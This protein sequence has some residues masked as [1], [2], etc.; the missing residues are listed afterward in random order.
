M[1]YLVLLPE[2]RIWI[3]P[4]PLFDRAVQSCC[5]C[6]ISPVFMFETVCTTCATNT[7]THS[8]L[9]LWG[10]RGVRGTRLLPESLWK[11][12]S[13][14][15]AVKELGPLRA[16]CSSL[17]TYTEHERS[18]VVWSSEDSSAEEHIKEPNLKNPLKPAQ[19]KRL[20]CPI[21]RLT[22]KPALVLLVSTAWTFTGAQYYYQ[23]LMDYLENRLLA[24][25]VRSKTPLTDW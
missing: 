4:P 24:I 18:K 13:K 9:T 10:Q 22:M 25:E 6:A 8:T 12:S 16:A 19:T 5:V 21:D 11:H 23:G 1:E 15:R 3:L 14:V 2:W 17:C 7:H 20:S